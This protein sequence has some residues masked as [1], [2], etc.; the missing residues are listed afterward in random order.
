MTSS[1]SAQRKRVGPFSDV[2]DQIDYYFPSD[3]RPHPYRQLEARIEKYLDPEGA[4]LDVGCGYGAP[5]L[6]K[7]QGRASR[8]VGI[9][10]IEFDEQVEGLDLFQ[11]SVSDMPLIAD[12]S[13]SLA[14]SRS[15]MEHV[16]DA[17]GAFREL[18]RVLRPGGHYVFLTPNRYDYASIFASIVPN[19][20]HGK[21]VKYVSG[22]DERDTFPTCYNANTFRD[23]RRLSAANGF[24]IVEIQRLTQYPSYFLFSRPLFYLGCHY[25]N[26]LDAVPM[27]DVLKGWILCVVQREP[28]A[29]GS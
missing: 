26:L 17:D 23:I 16:E 6:R 12:G 8:L 24:R 27:L 28:V 1:S 29:G 18:A 4:V 2:Q 9:D 25:E 11:A 14:Y 13:I 21:V 19:K 20:A 5:N 10:L 3:T 15:V 22:R 7:L